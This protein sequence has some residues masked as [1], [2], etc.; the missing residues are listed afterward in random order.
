M[1]ERWRCFVALLIDDELRR[2]LADHV[3]IWHDQPDVAGLRWTDP[4]SW[5]V[6]LAF[7]GHVDAGRVPG[8]AG[9]VRDVA[10]RHGPMRLSG[11]KIGAFPANGRARVVW[12]GIV[13]AD[14]SLERLASDLRRALDVDASQPF[15]PHVTIARARREPVDVR[16]FLARER[17][18]S[19]TWSAARVDLMRSHLGRGPARYEVV[20]SAALEHA[21]RV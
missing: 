20:E 5:H 14:G 6:T 7:L 3:A 4:D 19:M 11:G 21:A 8:I 12:Y 9:A 18:P 10:E 13:S 15:R 2:V 1:S 17:G 16:G